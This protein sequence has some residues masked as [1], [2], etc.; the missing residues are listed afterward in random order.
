[1]ATTDVISDVK[2]KDDQDFVHAMRVPPRLASLQ[3][4]VHGQV[5]SLSENKPVDLQVTQ[6]YTMNQ[7]DKSFATEDLHLRLD[8]QSTGWM[9]WANPA[10]RKQTGRYR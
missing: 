9:F 2:L 4:T 10:N 1:M 5:K 6:T 7:I 8:D 3:F